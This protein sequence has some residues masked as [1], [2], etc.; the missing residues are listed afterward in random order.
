[1]M[2]PTQIIDYCFGDVAVESSFNSAGT[3]E[4]ESGLGVGGTTLF[5]AEFNGAP[6]AI[7]QRWP[8]WPCGGFIPGLV[9]T[10]GAFDFTIVGIATLETE[11]AGVVVD[12]LGVEFSGAPTAI[13]QRWPAWPW[14]GFIPTPFKLEFCCVEGAFGVELF[15]NAEETEVVDALALSD[16][17]VTAELSCGSNSF[18]QE[19]IN[20]KNTSSAL[21]I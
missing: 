1:M 3:G 6:T 9:T 7:S 19:Q 8:V 13:S 14:G 12:L 15:V 20:S 2:N 5:G 21:K 16:G 10:A 17:I 11:L 18:L 4:P